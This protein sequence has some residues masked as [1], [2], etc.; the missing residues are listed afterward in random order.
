M[1]RPRIDA[2]FRDL[3]MRI[4]NQLA[5]NDWKDFNEKKERIEHVRFFNRIYTLESCDTEAKV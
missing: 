3:R 4:R 5:R 1:T 2:I